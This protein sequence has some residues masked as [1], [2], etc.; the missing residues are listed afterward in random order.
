[1]T[2]D[3]STVSRAIVVWTGWGETSRPV[4]TETRLADRIGEEAAIS[5]LPLIRHLEEEFYSSDARFVVADLKEMGDVAAGQFRQAHPE[6]SDEAIRALAWCYTF[7]Y[8]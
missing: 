8:K 4:R 5:L 6:L 7:D 3:A 1:M 2:L